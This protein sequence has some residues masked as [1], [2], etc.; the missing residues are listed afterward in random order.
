MVKEKI[1]NHV[2]HEHVEKKCY[3]M[4]DRNEKQKTRN[5]T[6]NENCKHMKRINTKNMSS[7]G[8][9]ACA[10]ELVIDPLSWGLWTVFICN[11]L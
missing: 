10:G 8:S 2:A 7:V 11:I 6:N 4:S 3:K 1:K 5:V 9:N